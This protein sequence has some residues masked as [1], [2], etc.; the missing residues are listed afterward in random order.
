MMYHPHGET[1]N[2]SVITSEGQ[3]WTNNICTVVPQGNFGSIRGD[4]PA[5]GR[6]IEAKL[7]EYIIDCFFADFIHNL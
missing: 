6:Y 7:S 5:A 3:Y 1:S 2:I 4:E